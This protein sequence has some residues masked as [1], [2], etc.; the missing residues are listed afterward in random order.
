[1]ENLVQSADE[2]PMN[3][4][5]KCTCCDFCWHSREEF[6]QDPKLELIGYQVNFDN[7][8]LGYFL[9]NHLTCESTIAIAAG[10]FTDLYNG[11]VFTER[12][13]GSDSCPGYCLHDDI[14]QPCTASCECAYV[15]EILQ[16]IRNWPKDDDR[17]VKAAQGSG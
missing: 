11:P 1:L 16:I 4:F 13:T 6:L 2:S 10:S 5:K 17:T 9:F 14:L 7:L 15:R 8:Q 3:I 12:L